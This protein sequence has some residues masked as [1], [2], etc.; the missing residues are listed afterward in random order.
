MGLAEDDGFVPHA[1]RHT[2]ATR[3]LEADTPLAVVSEHLGY[4]NQLV[5]AATYQHVTHE[6]ARATLAVESAILG[7]GPPT[8]H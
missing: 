3:A 7:T 6:F 4:A 1:L 5:T 8:D 2:W